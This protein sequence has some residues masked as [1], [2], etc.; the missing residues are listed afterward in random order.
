V[1][2]RRREVDVA[3]LERVLVLRVADDS[4]R[5]ALQ[6]ARETALRRLDGAMLC[7]DDRL[8]DLVREVGEQ[9]RQGVEAAPG[10][11]DRDQLVDQATFR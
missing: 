2:V 3:A 4:R 6:Q 8:V 7:D 5:V 9:A 11:S 10:G 1:V